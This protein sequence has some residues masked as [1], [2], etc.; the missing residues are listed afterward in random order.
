MATTILQLK[1]LGIADPVNFDFIEKPTLSSLRYGFELLHSLGALTADGGLSKEGWQMAKIPLEPQHA[2]LLLCAVKFEC[3]DD[4][5]SVMSM[6][7]A[8]G[9]GGSVFV[10]PED[11]KKEA[12]N[13]RRRFGAASGDL[14]TLLRVYQGWNAHKQ[15]TAKVRWC[16]DHFVNWRTMDKAGNIRQQLRQI[17]VRMALPFQSGPHKD[18]QYT[19]LRR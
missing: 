9:D 4:V 18:Q 13:S 7:S 12:H 3:L 6:V 17:C 11:K 5:L 14:V 10:A 16:Q 19:A 2:K 1:V 15:H 8:E